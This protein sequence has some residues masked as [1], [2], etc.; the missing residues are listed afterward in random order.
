MGVYIYGPQQLGG[1][2]PVVATTFS[3]V[4]I[5]DHEVTVGDPNNVDWHMFNSLTLGQHGGEGAV[6]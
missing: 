1:S 5:L 4:S 2:A 6:K 3:G